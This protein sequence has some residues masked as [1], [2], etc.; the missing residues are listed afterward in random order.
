M[1]PKGP[2]RGP[3]GVTKM[4]PRRPGDPNGV[5]RAPRGAPRVPQGSPEGPKELQMTLKVRKTM[6]KAASRPPVLGGDYRFFDVIY[7]LTRQKTTK[8]R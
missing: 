5:P 2:Q 1:R 6:Q 7:L 3:E 4:V 8:I